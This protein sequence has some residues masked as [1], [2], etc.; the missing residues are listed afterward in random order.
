V[1][2]LGNEKPV[3][4]HGGWAPLRYVMERQDTTAGIRFFH[5]E[6]KIELYLP[7]VFP[8]LAPEIVIPRPR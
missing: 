5:P 1:D 8:S 3:Y 6:T 4:V 2:S 7:P